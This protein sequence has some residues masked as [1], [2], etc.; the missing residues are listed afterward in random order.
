[1]VVGEV[2]HRVLQRFF[3]TREG[4]NKIAIWH[5]TLRFEPY[6][7]GCEHRDIELVI[8]H[9]TAEVEGLI[10]LQLEGVTDPF[11]GLCGNHIH[12]RREHHGLSVAGSI[13]AITH[14]Q[15]DS[16]V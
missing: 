15:R 13:A 7:H 8:E 14:Y 16:F 11:T 3:I 4:D 12:V 10:L 2:L 6:K 1:M 9:A 5:K